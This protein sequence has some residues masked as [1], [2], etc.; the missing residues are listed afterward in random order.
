MRPGVPGPALQAARDAVLTWSTVG[1]LAEARRWYR[2]AILADPFSAGIVAEAVEFLE[3]TGRV[4]EAEQLRFEL[5]E[6]RSGA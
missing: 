2:L 4:A 3:S 5:A 1:R 6:R